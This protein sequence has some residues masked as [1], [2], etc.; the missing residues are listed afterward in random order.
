M[1]SGKVLLLVLDGVGIGATPDAEA[2]GDAG[3]N[4]LGHL[5]EAVAG[6]TLPHLAQ[7]GLGNIAPLRGLPPARPP[8]ASFGKMA[9]ASQGKDS[10]TGHWE[11]AGLIT[12][13]PFPTYPTGFPAELVERFL[14]VTGCGG[15][16]GNKP[17]SG[18]AI[19]QELGTEHLR[20]GWP[21]VY[22][23]ADSVFQIAAH[24]EV[25]PLPRLYQICQLTREQVCVGQHQVSRVI[26]RPF[27]GAPGAFVRTANRR[28]FS[29]APPQPT[30]LDVLSEAGVPVTTIG[31]VDDLFASRGVGLALHTRSNAETV[32][33]LLHQSRSQTRGLIF[34][35]LVDFDTLYGHRNDPLGFARALVEFDA[36]LPAIQQT[37]GQE[38]LLI[39]TADHGNDPTTPSTDHSREYVP[40]LVYRP[41]R[42]VGVDLGIRASFADVG[43]T[44]ADYFG[45][46]NRLDGESFLRALG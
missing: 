20:T 24:E 12:R 4:T 8:R 9:Q 31:K 16:L 14:A 40:L 35:T 41:G 22:T 36:V 18:T 23:S 38:D 21:I 10:T 17:A 25:I 1:N 19:I 42:P 43:R 2:Y 32:A 30:L 5:V 27:V 7:L 13:Q 26:A 44:I 15:V 28:D 3:S 6:L 46:P 34:A 11:L 29:V 37:L 39:I 33:T 45:V